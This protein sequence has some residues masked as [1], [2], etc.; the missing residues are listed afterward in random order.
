MS[1]KKSRFTSKEIQE[2]LQHERSQKKHIDEEKLREAKRLNRMHENWLE[3][4]TWEEIEARISVIGLRRGTA[5]YREIRLL[6]D[7]VQKR[8][9]ER[10]KPP[11]DD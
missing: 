4:A 7:Q 5:P 1:K 6:Y 2:H 10:K 3:H 9:Q 11:S 8:R